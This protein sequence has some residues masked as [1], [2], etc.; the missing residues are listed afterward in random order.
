[1]DWCRKGKVNK[2]VYFHNLRFDGEFLFHYLLSQGFTYSD[3]KES[4]TFNCIISGQGQFYS[5]EVVFKKMNKKLKKVT[6]LDSNKKLP[7]PVAGVAKAFGLSMSKGDIDHD[8]VRPVGHVMTDE[9]LDYLKRD[10]Q[11][12]AM[13]LGI[14]ME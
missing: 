5:I 13:A 9:E 14:Q 10:V 1:M 4:N 6:F 11:I 2:T 12:V 3:K 8:I 7:M